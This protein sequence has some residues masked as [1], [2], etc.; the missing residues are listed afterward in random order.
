MSFWMGMAVALE[1]AQDKQHEIDKMNLAHEQKK[2]LMG[3]QQAHQRSMVTG[4]YRRSGGGGYYRRGGGGGYNNSGGGDWRNSGNND[5][6]W[7][8]TSYKLRTMA[9]LMGADE[10]AIGVV[11]NLHDTG[12]ALDVWH[13]FLEKA[14]PDTK[15]AVAGMIKEAV[16]EQTYTP[17]TVQVEPVGSVSDPGT[18]FSFG[19]TLKKIEEARENTEIDLDPNSDVGMFNL[20]MAFKTGGE[21]VSSTPVTGTN[22]D[23]KYIE[24][25]S[26]GEY[27]PPDLYDFSGISLRDRVDYNFIEDKAES[28]LGPL[29]NL[30][31]E[32]NSW[33][34]TKFDVG[35]DGEADRVRKDTMDFNIAKT[36]ITYAYDRWREKNPGGTEADYIRALT[37]DVYD[38]YNGA[39][40]SGGSFMEALS[41]YSQTLEIPDFKS[42]PNL[43]VATPT[44]ELAP[45]PEAPPAVFTPPVQPVVGEIET[46][47]RGPEVS[48]A[49]P[50]LKPP[51]N[52]DTRP[53][54]PISYDPLPKALTA[55]PSTPPLGNPGVN[56]PTVSIAPPVPL[57]PITTLPVI[58]PA[59]ANSYTSKGDGMYR[60]AQGNTWLFSGGKL[61]QLN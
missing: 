24:H 47:T 23:R 5:S 54:A 46:G 20:A 16:I 56:P 48:M 52:L 39:T 8:S 12:Q 51:V 34:P 42:T 1:R 7:K 60:D 40:N 33:V 28:I 49:P 6:D 32:D 26:G 58:D 38:I 31:K 55:G 37:R 29:F 4:G 30:K 41:D 9:S 27:D 61:T 50:G 14:A 17:E 35:V 2:E 57:S 25:R 59:N 53:P 22:F 18:K 45:S 10:D 44:P 19:T 36:D 21:H 15:T 11:K 13:S 3:M 43:S